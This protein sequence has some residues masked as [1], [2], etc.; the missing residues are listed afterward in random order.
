MKFITFLTACFT[1]SGA[2]AAQPFDP[3]LFQDLRWR[4]IGPF[5]GGRTLAVAGLSGQPNAYYFGSV[6]GGVWKTTNG[7]E[8]WRPLFQHESVASIGALAIS[9]ADAHVI[10]AGTGEADMRSDI[11]FGAGIYK[12]T[13][14]GLTW[15]NIEIGRAHV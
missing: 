6:D 13:D 7:G 3:S 15:K 10:Y 8:T 11:T 4:S 14:G 2:L 12:S 5:R 1:L 9:P